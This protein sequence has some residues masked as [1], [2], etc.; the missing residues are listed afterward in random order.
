[1]VSVVLTNFRRYKLELVFPATSVEK[2]LAAEENRN[3]PLA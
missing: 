1:M 2:V 3:L